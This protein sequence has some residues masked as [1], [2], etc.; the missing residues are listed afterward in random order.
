MT[1]K[2]LSRMLILLLVTLPA[3]MQAEELFTDPNT[4]M[5][6]VMVK[7]GCFKMGDS[8]GEGD[9]NEQP[10]REVCVSDFY[11]GKYEVTNA[12]YVKFHPEHH[13]GSSEE[14]ELDKPQMPVV[15]VSWK[16]AVEFASWLS[17][18]SGQQYRLPTEAEWEFAARAGSEKSRFWGNDA[19]KAC[20][21]ANVA[22]MTAKKHRPKWTAFHC[23][24]KHATAAPVGSFKANSLG[25]YDV[26]GNAWEWCQDVY[27][28]EAYTKLPQ[29]DPLYSG[30]GEY[31]VMRGG[32]WSNGPLGIRCSHRV[33]LSPDFGHHALGIRLV[34]SSR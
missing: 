11:I 3:T 15:N 13:S 18:K 26:L 4:G 25:V 28:N 34:K 9:P 21:Y 8:V 10:V 22:D 14:P 32:G 23:D 30:S 24:D 20:G 2:M 17:Q 5:E 29:D 12:Q 19:D 27:N 6:F 7:G 31:R 1:M 33:G 16:D